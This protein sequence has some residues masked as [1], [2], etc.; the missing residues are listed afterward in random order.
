MVWRFLNTIGEA[1]REEFDEEDGGLWGRWEGPSGATIIP[2][3]LHYH[4]R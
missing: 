2:P 4:L 3:G 1:V